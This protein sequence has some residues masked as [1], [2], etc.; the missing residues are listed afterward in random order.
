M[1]SYLTNVVA[2]D[3]MALMARRSAFRLCLA[4]APAIAALA[5]TVAV[6]ARPS[7]ASAAGAR[8][9]F[10]TRPAPQG[11][12]VTQFTGASSVEWSSWVGRSDV[13]A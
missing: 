2:D 7:A 4:I 12:S 8:I 6:L 3:T 9:S 1:S 13:P 10:A 5:I 11:R